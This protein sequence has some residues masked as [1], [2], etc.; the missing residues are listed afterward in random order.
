MS[1]S[2]TSVR[3]FVV[4]LGVS[5]ILVGVS[6]N[7]RA[8][9]APAPTNAPTVATPDS[10]S[11]AVA[12]AL[13]LATPPQ[14]VSL[15]VPNSSSDTVPLI[16]STSSIS[17]APANTSRPK[18]LVPL[19]ISFAALQALDMHSTLSGLQT[20]GREA[21]PVA[22]TFVGSTAGF[23]SLKIASAGA[24]IYLTERVRKHNRTAAIVTMIALDSVYAIVVEHNYAVQQR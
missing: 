12:P 9:N 16:P 20:G 2:R 7:A 4:C 24:V 8:Q 17:T 11:S 5:S 19:W 15:V 13:A 6:T 14:L 18:A 21:N 22:G 1:A 10:D 23:A 3:S